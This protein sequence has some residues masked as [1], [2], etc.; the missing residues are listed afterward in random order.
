MKLLFSRQMVPRHCSFFTVQRSLSSE[1]TWVGLQQ[2]KE[3]FGSELASAV[4]DHFWNNQQEDFGMVYRHRDYCGISLAWQGGKL[5]LC[6]TNDGFLEFPIMQWSKTQKKI[7]SVWL[8]HQSDYSLSGHDV[9]SKFY[10]PDE[11]FRGNQRI[12]AARLRE[13]LTIIT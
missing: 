5:S 10:E 6:P 7:F 12:N 8:A 13:F 9:S 11:F 4:A 1:Y 2:S 3:P